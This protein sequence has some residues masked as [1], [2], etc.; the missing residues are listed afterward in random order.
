[1]TGSLRASCKLD[2]RREA[3]GI[4]EGRMIAGA[5]GMLGILAEGVNNA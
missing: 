1:M 3:T 4:R 2:D 5:F